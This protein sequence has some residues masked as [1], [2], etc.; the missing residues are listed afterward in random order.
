MVNR[1]RTPTGGRAARLALIATLL[2]PALALAQ[3]PQGWGP[4]QFRPNPADNARGMPP[5]G[6]PAQ[7]APYGQQ[8]WPGGYAPPAQGMPYGGPGGYGQ[9]PGQ[10]A[11]YQ[12]GYGQPPGQAAPYQGSYPG[13]GQYPGQTVSA[14]RP[15]RL[16]VEVPDTRPYVQQNLLVTLRVASPTSLATASPT[17]SGYDDVLLEKV[18][19]PTASSRRTDDGTEVITEY[20]LALTPLRTGAI[21]VGPLEVSGTL[22]GGVPFVAKASE[23]LKLQ[24]RPPEPGIQPWLAL[25]ALE[26]KADFDP[27]GVFAEGRP[28]GLVLTMQADGALGQQLPSLAASLQSPDFRVYREQT[29]TENR[30]SDDGRRLLGTRTEHYTL[31]PF[32]GGRLQLPELR[33]T[34]WNVDTGQRET[35]G[36]PI[37]TFTVAGE[38]GP[39][40][41][42]RSAS[43][44][45]Q[46][47]ALT[48]VWM[49]LA[50]IA[51][52]LTGYWGGVWL[53]GGARKAPARPRPAPRP[54]LAGV[55]L[56]I[57]HRLA[58]A[59]ADLGD[60]LRD[61]LRGLRDGLARTLDPRRLWRLLRT[62]GK[63][64]GQLL[65]PRATRV[66]RCA[67]HAEHATTPAAWA[68]AFQA[69]A[70]EAL[71]TRNREPL[72]RVADRIIAL[73]PGA[74]QARVRALINQLDN[75]LYNGQP[76]DFPRWKRDFRRALRPGLGD[77]DSLL[78]TRVRRARLPE[79]NPRAI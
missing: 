17:L 28:V 73:R 66:L 70:C 32:S 68:N 59:L 54:G 38:A 69:R 45:D 77:L 19:G 3:A 8:G 14:N 18:A 1:H 4:W 7:P 21:V 9:P 47:G 44:R 74:D 33:V 79:L 13:A 25:R 53:R 29:R 34:W 64:L 24:V 20:T 72:P 5:G 51:L 52:L 23:A 31:V 46:G 56:R 71:D 15:P 65:T 2:A 10:G 35:S 62:L 30:V 50:A 16:T 78:A 60:R 36:V 48:W 22:A 41:L 43:G 42:G 61:G 49:P 37:R 39:L 76:L 11:P 58:D 26:L 63:R 67:V 6:A 27:N 75:A 40:G 55:P 12:G 57:R